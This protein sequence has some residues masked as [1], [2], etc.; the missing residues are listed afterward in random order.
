MRF[1]L[2]ELERVDSTNEL[3]R[4]MAARGAP[5]GTVVV[6][7]EQ[8]AGRGRLGRRWSSP[9]GGLWLSLLLRP[10]APPPPERLGSLAPALGLAVLE[11]VG[12]WAGGHRLGLK[13]PND[14]VALEEA[15]GEA[16]GRGAE[17]MG[18]W[19]KLA[20]ILCE[21]I[22]AGEGGR[23]GAAVIAGFG[24]NAD[25]EVERLPAELR[26]QATSLRRLG[27]GPVPLTELRRRL[28]EATERIWTVWQVG[29]FAPL[30]TAWLERAVWL[31]EAVRLR[32]A[33]PEAVEAAQT[34][35]AGTFAGVDE[36]AALL[37]RLED[38]RLRRFFAGELSLRRPTS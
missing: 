18:G 6:A 9:R 25:F 13:W 24:I 12:P 28:L 23:P 1:R 36:E 16:S 32:G 27:G 8:E 33:P 5:E 11:A 21:A 10:P 14:V 20:G 15:G 38:G 26:G 4:A 17:A 31:G 3:L 34:E 29:G 37:L 7:A 22:P 30:R 35:V 2:F 19:R